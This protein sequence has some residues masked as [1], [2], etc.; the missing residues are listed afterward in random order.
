MFNIYVLIVSLL[1]ISLFYVVLFMSSEPLIMGK[2][3][4]LEKS[5]E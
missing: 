1:M 2:K 4:T 5:D 3:R